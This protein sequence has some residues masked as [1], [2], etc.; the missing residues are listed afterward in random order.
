[1]IATKYCSRYIMSMGNYASLCIFLIKFALIWC[2]ARSCPDHTGFARQVVHLLAF[3][4]MR[5]ALA[6]IQRANVTSISRKTPSHWREGTVDSDSEVTQRAS[7]RI[8]SS[9][10]V[11]TPRD[12]GRCATSRPGSPQH[13]RRHIPTTIACMTCGRGSKW[14][15]LTTDQGCKR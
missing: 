2:S 7:L 11:R 15:L 13:M 14:R 9:S 1:M 8:S 10:A 5:P 4:T 6:L 3:V 12:R